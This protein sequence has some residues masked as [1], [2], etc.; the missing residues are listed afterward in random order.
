MSKVGIHVNNKLFTIACDDGQENRV[1]QLGAYIDERFR[2][3]NQA[4]AAPNESY[5]LVLTSLVIADEMMEA[6]QQAEA[7]RSHAGPQGPSQQEIE[8]Y[9]AQQYDVKIREL[10]AALQNT[11]AQLAQASTQLAQSV[12]SAQVDVDHIRREAIAEAQE[13]SR[14]KEQDIARAVDALTDRLEGM[15][16]RLRRA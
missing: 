1:K 10:E 4:G 14:A 13:T 7:A 9:V 16:K 15:V 3:L 5:M 2:E 11:R 8:A 6:K 12:P